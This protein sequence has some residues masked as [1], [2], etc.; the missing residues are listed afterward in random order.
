MLLKNRHACL[1]VCLILYLFVLVR[2]SSGNEGIQIFTGEFHENS[3]EVR[4]NVTEELK[5]K[6][7]N[8]TR[9][10]C[11]SCTLIIAQEALQEGEPMM[12]EPYTKH[13]RLH[14]TER[15]YCEDLNDNSTCV[16]KPE[17]RIATPNKTKT[18]EQAKGFEIIITQMALSVSINICFIK[19]RI[20][21]LQPPNVM[22]FIM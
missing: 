20:S 6:D 21:F 17:I 7:G 13:H 1:V 15:I 5:G 3:C 14:F 19:S 22:C 12:I 18:R 11:M 2:V 9:E 8:R 16:I 4:D 10:I